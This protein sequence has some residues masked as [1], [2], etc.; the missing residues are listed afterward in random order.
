[1][2]CFKE[3]F[4]NFLHWNIPFID[5]F[6]SSFTPQK[7]G[8]LE[9]G[10]QPHC[11]KTD[12]S[13]EK[14]M[15]QIAVT[16]N[17]KRTVAEKMEKEGKTFQFCA[18]NSKIDNH[19]TVWL[20]RQSIIREKIVSFD[21]GKEVARREQLDGEFEHF[22]SSETFLVSTTQWWWLYALKRREGEGNLDIW[23]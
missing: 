16:D 18:K 6:P 10:V 21:R 8:K 2:I 22:N 20:E 11:L 15:N 19:R 9:W 3:V 12:A 14:L 5:F 4:N 17:E 1:M 23:L 7:S 13:L